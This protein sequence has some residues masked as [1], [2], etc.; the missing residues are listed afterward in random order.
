MILFF[1]WTKHRHCLA[2]CQF[3]FLIRYTKWIPIHGIKFL[4][5]FKYCFIN[6]SSFDVYINN[7]LVTALICLFLRNCNTLSLDENLAY[8]IYFVFHIS[9]SHAFFCDNCFVHGYF[10]LKLT[11]YVSS[12]FMYSET[13][14]Q[15][16]LTKKVI[17]IHE[18]S[19]LST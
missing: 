2:S 5:L 16:D 7:L 18:I 12:L 11:W 10:E 17:D 15:L 1:N 4:Y 8:L 19:V 6:R 13:K 14:L 9:L 3:L